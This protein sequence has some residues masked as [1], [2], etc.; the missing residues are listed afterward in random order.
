MAGIAAASRKDTSVMSTERATRGSASSRSDRRS[1][2]CSWIPR[3][4]SDL[5]ASRRT[6][7]A[8]L[9]EHRDGLAQVARLRVLRA[10]RREVL[11]ELCPIAFRS[12]FPRRSDRADRPRGDLVRRLHHGGERLLA[13][14]ALYA[15]VPALAA[16]VLLRE[17]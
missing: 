13:L 16:R 5:N 3:L 1:A 6:A 2:R 10:G 11:V 14:L 7:S 12:A 4:S 15:E 8:R 17:R 9:F